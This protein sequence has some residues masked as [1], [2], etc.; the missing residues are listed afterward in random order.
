MNCDLA[1]T[2][3]IVSADG[4]HRAPMSIPGDVPSA[5]IAAGLI[6]HPYL[7]RNEYD[8][9]WVAETEWTASSAFTLDSVPEGHWYLDITGLDTVAAISINGTTVLEAANCFR[10]YRPDVTKALKEGRNEIAILF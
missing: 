8:V 6:A 5:L 2:W 3:T 9:R 10:R 4:R 1:G 7:G